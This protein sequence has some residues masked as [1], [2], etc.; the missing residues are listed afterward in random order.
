MSNKSRFICCQNRIAG[1]TLLEVLVASM[2]STLVIAGVTAALVQSFRSW[3]AAG[4]RSEL[5]INLEVSME[6]MRHDLR[7]SSVGIGLM[8][9][10]PSDASEYTAISFPLATP[11]AEGL[12]PRDSG[13]NIIWDTTVVYHVRPGSPDE[14]IRSTFHPRNQ[15]AA[16]SDFYQQLETVVQ[17]QDLSDVQ[18]AA[19][20]GETATSRVIFQNLV[21]MV[22][23]PPEM[24][25]DGYAQQYERASTVNWGSVVLGNGVHELTFTVENKN[26]ASKGYKVGV[27]RFA[28]SYSGSRREAE[29]FLPEHTRPAAPYFQATTSG[30]SMISEDMSMHGANWSGRSQLTYTPNYETH[31]PTGSRLTFHVHNDIWN[32]TTF[33]NPPGALALNCHRHVDTSFTNEPPYIPDVVIAMKEGLSWDVEN[34]TDGVP[35]STTVTNVVTAN[36][37]HGGTNE[38]AAV[39][40]NGSFAR[41]AFSAGS[42]HNLHVRN[43]QVGR[44]ASGNA[45]VAGTTEALTFNNG[46]VHVNIPSGGR[47]WSDWIRYEIDQNE[48]YLVQWERRDAGNAIPAGQT[49]A[50]MWIGDA[51][52]TLSYLDGVPV[53][54]MVALT[55]MEVRA[56][57]NAVYRSGVFDTRISSPNYTRM[58]WTQVDHGAD[59]NIGFRVRSSDHPDM[60][61]A[62]WFPLGFYL[63]NNQNSNISAVGNGRYIQYEA[64]FTVAGDHTELPVL[65][66]VTIAWEAPTGIVDLVVDLARGPDYGIITAEVNGQS[67]IRGVEIQLEIFREGPFGM[68][69]ATGITEVRPLNTGR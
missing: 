25:F 47:V 1:F 10:Y 54:Q 31:G 38:P 57:S 36:V 64:L 61:D 12:L 22:F 33:N 9:F 15:D 18:G 69:R 16:A 53:N 44:R 37:I 50:R 19:M 23:R 51:A 17:S 14:L 65:R 34:V 49:D 56:P 26:T 20:Q 66:D 46:S 52:H 55:A 63:T 59:G 11:D 60:H 42:S 6:R 13:G 30:G 3:R 4:V 45:F 62:V 24:R 68:E 39:F 32:D 40:L 58:T 67:F 5:H 29:W 8:A 41:F 48:S 28:M 2:I 21:N 35:Y 27:D 43:A 7:L